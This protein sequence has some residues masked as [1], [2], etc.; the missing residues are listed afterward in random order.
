MSPIV[1]QEN[2]R[3]VFRV[4]VHVHY[5]V[6]LVDDALAV[7]PSNPTTYQCLGDLQVQR[8]SIWCNRLLVAGEC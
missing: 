7:L 3:Q 4:L 8:L 6:D 5:Y 2:G 1:S